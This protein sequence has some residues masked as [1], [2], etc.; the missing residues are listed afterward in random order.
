M[1]KEYERTKDDI[2]EAI[3]SHYPALRSVTLT[4]EELAGIILALDGVLIKCDDQSLKNPYDW[5]ENPKMPART[6]NY[7]QQKSQ[8]FRRC[9]NDMLTPDSEGN[10]WVKC[11]PKEK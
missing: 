3:H 10:V 8:G 6:A 2:T 9:R 5:Q 7:H 1:G 4:C 11:L